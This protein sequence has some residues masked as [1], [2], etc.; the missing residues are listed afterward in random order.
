[1]LRSTAMRSMAPCQCWPGR[2]G[3]RRAPRATGSSTKRG[4]ILQHCHCALGRRCGRWRRVSAGLVGAAAGE[5]RELRGHQQSAAKFC[6]TVTV[7]LVSLAP[8]DQR[9]LPAVPLLLPLHARARGAIERCRPTDPPAGRQR[10]A[11]FLFR[12]FRI[13]ANDGARAVSGDAE[14]ANDAEV[15]GD[16]VDGAVSVL[17]WSGRRQA[18]A[19]SYGV[20]NK[21]RPNSAALSLCAWSRSLRHS[22]AREAPSS[23]AGRPTRLLAD[24][25]APEIFR[26]YGSRIGANDGA[27]AVSGAGEVANDAEVDGAADSFL[28]NS[29]FGSPSPDRGQRWSSSGQRRW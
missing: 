23:G 5:R 10:R 26:V 15:D 22:R 29:F 6:S 20:I 12:D 9:N 17:A 19:A 11:G 3:G 16:A 25:D 1:M 7:R 14:V 18:S 2:G 21:A 13:G 27:R 4:Q 28:A 24:S 8:K